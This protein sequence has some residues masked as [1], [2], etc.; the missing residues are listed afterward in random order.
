VRAVAPRSD[1]KVQNTAQG[2]GV[3][4]I[5]LRA[6][7]RGRRLAA[8]ALAAVLFAVAWTYTPIRSRTSFSPRPVVSS[9]RPFSIG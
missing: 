5:L 2:A 1:Q 6:D 3:S 7:D 4:F 9:Y 8:I